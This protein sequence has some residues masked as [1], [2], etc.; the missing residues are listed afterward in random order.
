MMMMMMKAADG[1]WL[2][3]ATATCH[4]SIYNFC[5]KLFYLKLVVRLAVFHVCLKTN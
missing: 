5:S 4:K 3:F 2:K 1:N